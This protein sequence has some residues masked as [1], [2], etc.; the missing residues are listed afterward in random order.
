MVRDLIMQFK[1]TTTFS[2]VIKP[3]VS[4]EKDI[5]LALASLA[6]IGKF[7]PEVD[8]A[9][10][11]DLLPVAFNAA[12]VNRV[13][14][15]GDVIDTETALA[16]YKNFINKPINV[17]HNR[18][19][20]VG[21]ILT[22]GFSEFGTDTILTE[23]QIKEL[24]GPFN[25]TLGGVIWKIAN[26]NLA[27]MIEDSSDSTS[28][29]YQKI[30]A[31]WELGFN[32][33]N[34]VMIEGESKNIEDGLEIKN[35]SEDFENLRA[36]LRA[37]GGSGKVD[38]NKSIYRKVIG[39][40]VPLGIGLTENPAADVKGVVT[41][42]PEPVIASENLEENISKIENFDVNTNID[43]KAMKLTSVKDITDENL[44]QISASVISD[45]MEQELKTASEKFT[46]EKAQVQNELQSAV[47]DLKN[48]KAA[49]ETLLQEVST[50]KEKLSVAEEEKA[51]ILASEKFN[52]RMNAFDTEY[53]LDPET[54]QVLAA[55]IAEMNDEAFA[56][57]KNKMAIFLKNK[58]KGQKMEDEKKEEAKSSVQQ[59]VEE[60]T[61]KAQQDKA[62]LSN[63]S[64]ASSA[65]FF[66]KYKNAFDY[67]S[68]VVTT[69]K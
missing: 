38:K 35:D 64:T 61:D 40:V 24:K 33:Y 15:N 23:E 48:L 26:P 6:E 32:D 17:E 12:V 56:A 36:S 25:I 2:S 14:K 42:Q 41:N 31:S 27:D 20:I 55:E 62:T 11:L 21:V 51:K 43:N 37:F 4:E 57:Y 19:R 65:S 10:N 5:Y 16:S 46:A 28:N 39:N 13:N 59:V 30:S 50:L 34:V 45:L 1:Y 67:D 66:D 22:A 52:D 60:V 3:L 29:N 68:F 69:K 18:E 47:E 49:Q 9:K 54:R 7:I 63:T 53:D 44:K 8:S 58:K